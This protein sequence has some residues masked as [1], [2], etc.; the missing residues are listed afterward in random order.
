VRNQEGFGRWRSMQAIAI[1][2]MQV[3]Q[4]PLVCIRPLRKLLQGHRHR[5]GNVYLDGGFCPQQPPE[6][7]ICI[8]MVVFHTKGA[9][10]RCRIPMKRAN[11]SQRSA[12]LPRWSYGE[13]LWSAWL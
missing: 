3:Q 9:H 7:E 10:V 4:Y 12:L 11:F 1:G 8:L 2:Q 13:P 5:R 6:Q